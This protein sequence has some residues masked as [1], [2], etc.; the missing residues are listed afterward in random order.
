MENH[1][2]QAKAKADRYKQQMIYDSFQT[3]LSTTTSQRKIS[4]F[5]LFVALV[6]TLVEW[7][8]VVFDDITTGCQGITL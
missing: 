4:H 7:R 5:T 6:Y 8:R 3:R 2:E 1:P